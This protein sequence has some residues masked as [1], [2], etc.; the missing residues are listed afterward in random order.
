MPLRLLDYLTI[1]RQLTRLLGHLR[2]RYLVVSPTTRCA[3]SNAPCIHPFR[4]LVWSPAKNRFVSGRAS[5]RS[6]GSW[7]V[8]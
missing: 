7:P 8:V 3:L 1:L 2:E 4:M 5:S 6:V